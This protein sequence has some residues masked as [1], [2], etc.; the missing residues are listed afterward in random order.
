MPRS[1][2]T[3]VAARGLAPDDSAA[4]LG[5]GTLA[6]LLGRY[7]ALGEPLSCRPLTEGLL[8]RGYRLTTTRGRYFLKH[9]LDGDQA[10]IARQHRATLRLAGL[11]VPVAPPVAAADG[12]TVT[13]VGGRCYDADS[14]H[15]EAAADGSE[16]GAVDVWSVQFVGTARLF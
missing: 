12:S 3:A 2:V 5:P 16:S 6:A 10:A 8:N 4:T 1:P 14:A 13:V 7:P 15:A 9:H 11:G